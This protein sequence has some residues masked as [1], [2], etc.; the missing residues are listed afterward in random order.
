MP[1]KRPKRCAL[2]SGPIPVRYSYVTSPL[3]HDCYVILH[4]RLAI[5]F[6]TSH[7]AT[8]GRFQL[9]EDIWIESLDT[10][11]ATRVIRACEP[12][13]H[14]ID[15]SVHDTHL[16]A[17]V[18]QIPKTLPPPGTVMP[19]QHCHLP[20]LFTVIA[21]SRLIRPTST[22]DR[23]I[24]QVLPWG[25]DPAIQA[26]QV[27]GVCADVFLGDS[28]ADWLTPD[29]GDELRQLM[30][31]ISEDRKMYDRIH[32]AFWHHENAMRTYYLDTRW[33]L[34]VAGL[35][36][37]VNVEENNVRFQFKSRVS[38]LAAALGVDLTPDEAHDAFTIRSKLSHGQSFLF[39]VGTVLA[40]DKH[41]P[42]Y[43]KL[44]TLLRRAVKRCLTDA[45]FAGHFTDATTVN[46]KWPCCARCAAEIGPTEPVRIRSEDGKRMC[47]TCFVKVG[48]KR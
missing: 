21:L 16:Y 38:R 29:D 3:P 25:D 18:R 2:G 47:A 12:P 30:P 46:A 4:T 44:E 28:S 43:D 27:K 20:P 1:S 35:E 33:T 37:L 19:A 36:A 22:G 34:V 13:H 9:S 5:P 7:I 24:A 31:W 8:N 17:F 10:E 32:R 26:V 23:Y 11:F 48:R 42:L 14:R 40:P 39:G 41:R 6:P 45:T 15:K